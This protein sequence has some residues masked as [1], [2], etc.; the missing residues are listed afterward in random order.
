MTTN[1]RKALIEAK[2]DLDDAQERL[3]CAKASTE[4]ARAY[5]VTVES[6]V[7]ELQDVQDG[8]SA[9][10]AIALIASI[11]AGK[12]PAAVAEATRLVELDHALAAADTAR[13]ALATIHG[14]ERAAEKDV[15]DGKE[16]VAHAVKG[17]LAEEAAAIADRLERL[18][19]E[20]LEL[21][22][23]IG[24]ERGFLNMRLHPMG[25]RLAKIVRKNEA[26]D[27]FAVRNMP[28]NL[29]ADQLSGVWDSFAKALMA[30]P[31][32]VLSF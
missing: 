12:P 17:V 20:A 18:D 16:A 8:R 7:K 10:A 14:A 3:A 32:A 23:R 26:M 25:E 21:R 27:D 22:A 15:V 6:T 19:V 13:Q 31:K 5:L 24:R 4:S 29:R 28:G 11:K 2:H 30:N 1:A 9:S